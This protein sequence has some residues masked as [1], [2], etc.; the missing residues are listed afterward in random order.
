MGALRF[1]IETYGSDGEP[2]AVWMYEWLSLDACKREAREI[3][4]NE[5]AA[6]TVVWE[7]WLS[8]APRLL[9]IQGQVA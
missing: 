8:G 6:T 4:R 2:R 9:T 7:G 3:H 1:T 5:Q